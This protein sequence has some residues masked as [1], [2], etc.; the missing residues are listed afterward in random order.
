M[1]LENKLELVRQ[2][3]AQYEQDQYDLGRRE[4]I[5]Y[6]YSKENQTKPDTSYSDHSAGRVR[7]VVAVIL[8]LFVISCDRKKVEILGYQTESLFT[9]LARDVGSELENWIATSS[10]VIDSQVH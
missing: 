3:R 4:Q 6:G 8:L 5:L 2:I 9:A 10:T 7:L 1:T